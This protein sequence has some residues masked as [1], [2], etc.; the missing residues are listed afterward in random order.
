MSKRDKYE[1]KRRLINRN[2]D[3]FEDESDVSEIDFEAQ[4]DED[5][6]ENESVD[7]MGMNTEK[8]YEIE[9]ENFKRYIR[10]SR[11]KQRNLIV[12][13]LF[14]C[15]IIAGGLVFGAYVINTEKSSHEPFFAELV[16]LEKS[17]KLTDD[18]QSVA[19]S[20]NVAGYRAEVT[21][22]QGYEYL[23]LNL[24]MDKQ[25]VAFYFQNE[26][27]G[28]GAENV[29]ELTKYYIQ[30]GNDVLPISM[31]YD[32]DNIEAALPKVID[33][34]GGGNGF[35]YIEYKGSV[36]DTMTLYNIS[37]L[38]KVDGI[39]LA[40]TLAY[41]FDVSD[42]GEESFLLNVMH[43]IDVYTYQVDENRYNSGRGSGSSM[44]QFYDGLEFAFEGY[45]FKFKANVSLGEKA[46]IGRYD[47]TFIF[48]GSGIQMGTASYYT[49]VTPEYMLEENQILTPSNHIWE[50]AVVYDNKLL[51]AFEN[52][53]LNDIDNS[54]IVR[55][56]EG[57]RYYTD[58]SGNEIT[59]FG[60]DVSDHQGA[61]D[62]K[63]VADFGVKYAFVRAGYRGYTSG[64]IQPDDNFQSNIKGAIDAGLDVGVYFY[65]QAITA[66]EAKEEAE[67]VINQIKD[68]KITGPIVFDSELV[69]AEEGGRA[70][71]LSRAD[72][73]AVARA[74]FD[75][76]IA[77]GYKPMLYANT[78][79]LLFRL[80]LDELADVPIWYAYYG[81]EPAL[82]YKFAIWQYSSTGNLP[83]VES[84]ETDLNIMF[85]DVFK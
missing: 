75:T 85:E 55:P 6:D 10:K 4:D 34:Q 36:P 22:V 49:Y 42:G 82:P 35:L 44:L 70:N 28:A 63:T 76:V 54:R 84:D 2:D 16:K 80:D 24:T 18:L 3:E 74:F 32:F 48:T 53:P 25:E 23:R 68:Y 20:F 45:E 71:N 40:A 73:T 83:G 1:E 33:L 65:T 61:I 79:W 77:A 11:R 8:S 37:S 78:N 66:E 57:H 64:S 27:P 19:G 29:P 30:R 5:F 7:F 9:H 26:F 21:Q 60:I 15:L 62:W 69:E 58:E 47:G 50:N 31:E 56:E 41:Y 14:L 17:Y 59:S 38:E 46:Y 51:E 72:R 43:D 13:I 52:I 39:N 12:F 81:D 67:Y